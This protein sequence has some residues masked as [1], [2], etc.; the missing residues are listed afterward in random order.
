M[1]T[2]FRDPSISAS[3]GIK[4]HSGLEGSYRKLEMGQAHAQEQYSSKL[5]RTQFV[6]Y[7]REHLAK[8]IEYGQPLEPVRTDAR[9]ERTPNREPDRDYHPTR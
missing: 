4:R 1:A 2:V 6:D 5:H 3:E 8:S 7:L 9:E